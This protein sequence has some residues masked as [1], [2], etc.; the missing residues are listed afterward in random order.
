MKALLLEMMGRMMLDGYVTRVS[1][2]HLGEFV[3]DADRRVQALTGFSGSQGTAVTSRNESVLYTDAR[4]FLQAE[5]ELREYGLM[6]EGDSEPMNMFLGRRFGGRRL[7]IPLRQFPSKRYRELREGLEGMDVEVV[8]V[9]DDLVDAVWTDRPVRRFGEVASIEGVSLDGFGDVVGEPYRNKIR[10]VRDLIGD[11]EGMLVCDLNT[12]AW[13]LNLRGS[14]IPY[15]SVFYSYLFITKTDAKL[16][17]HSSVDLD[18]VEC[19]RYEDFDGFLGKVGDVVVSGDCNAYIHSRLGNV[20]YSEGINE[21]KSIKN[22]REIAGFGLA[23]VLD[24]VALTRLFGWMGTAIDSGI[25]EQDVSDKLLE[26]KR[27]GMGFVGSSFSTI[28]GAGE[29]G[30][31]LHHEAG[32]RVVGRE[33]LVLIDAGSHYVFGTTDISRTVHFGRPSAEMRRNFTLVL[34][35]TV[36]A[37][38]LR[39]EI[40]ARDIDDAARMPLREC[41][42]GYNTAT[43]HGVGHF[44]SVHECP[45]VVAGRDDVLE[46]GMVFT[47]EPGL[48]MEGVYGIRTEDVV[49]V[50]RDA[51][52]HVVRNLSLAPLCLDLIDTGLLTSEE[53]GYINLYS[54]AVHAALSPHLRDEALEYLRHNTRR[55]GE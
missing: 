31:I 46:E 29:N 13:I 43:G 37:R 3:H 26:L 4:Y 33:D 53:L 5:G 2:D 51:E 8:P 44:L 35:G 19:C 55:L 47:V 45:P 22:A 18:G 36:D 25:C 21:M 15:Q 23:G 39:G 34:R 40:R 41:G 10:R 20:R 17:S 42:L 16:F 30:A 38:M 6:K 24:G 9:D 7:G 11:G 52:G 48:S 12:I 49:V 14:D 1:D 54:K 50:S 27:E 32:E 28:V